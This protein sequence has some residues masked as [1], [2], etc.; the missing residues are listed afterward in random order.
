VERGAGGWDHHHL[1][2][3][4]RVL[5]VAASRECGQG[6]AV[7]PRRAVYDLSPVEKGGEPPAAGAGTGCK[8]ASS[9]AARRR[10]HI[11]LNVQNADY[12]QPAEFTVEM[13]IG[14][15]SASYA[16]S[17]GRGGARRLLGDDWLVSLLGRAAGADGGARWCC[18]ATQMMAQAASPAAVAGTRAVPAGSARPPAFWHCRRCA[19]CA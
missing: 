8:P 10:D 6:F 1:A 4:R 18:S 17:G 12:A 19:G 15:R 13:G 14:Y 7:S 9:E 11:E 5:S 16:R 3:P 2:G